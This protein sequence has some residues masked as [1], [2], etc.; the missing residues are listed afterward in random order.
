MAAIRTWPSRRASPPVSHKRL[1]KDSTPLTLVKTSQSNSPSRASAASIGVQSSGGEILDRRQQ[2]GFRPQLDEP[3]DHRACLRGRSR[4]GDA[5][6]EEGPFFEPGDRLAARHAFADDNDRRRTQLRAP[7][8]PLQA[9]RAGPRSSA[10]KGLSHSKP[11]RPAYRPAFHR[12]GAPPP[13]LRAGRAPCRK[14]AFPE[15]GP[16]MR[17]RGPGGP[18]PGSRAP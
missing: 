5:T 9:G 12:P 11:R 15:N 3:L 7:A 14:Q 4:N 17:N 18:W 10:A 13:M 1:R 6:S 16:A 8:R 2:N